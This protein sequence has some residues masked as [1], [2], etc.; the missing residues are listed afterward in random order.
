MS[1]SFKKTSAKTALL[2]ATFILGG[3]TLGACSS[4]EQRAQAY[5]EQGKS[6]LAKKDY[7]KAAIEFKNALQ[8]KKD[9]VEAFRGL[10]QIDEHNKNFQGLAGDLRSIVELDPKD[11]EARVKL[12]KLYLLGNALDPALKLANA[13][14]DQEPQNPEFLALKGSGASATQRRQWS[15]SGCGKG[16]QNRSR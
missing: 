9:M 16:R 15:H 7:V 10:E 11:N 14:V 2:L 13:A 1:R 3:V 5:Y 6:Y 4:R 12:T 8:I